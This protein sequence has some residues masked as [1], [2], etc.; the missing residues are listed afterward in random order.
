MILVDDS[1]HAARSSRQGDG[2]RAVE[3][4]AE[5][6]KLLDE[7]SSYCRD[8]GIAESTFGRL[9]I[10]DGKLMSR[11]RTGGRV[12]EE[13]GARVRAF[14]QTSR[15]PLRRRAA[16]SATAVNGARA[17]RPHHLSPELENTFRFF[18][19]RQKY[20]MFVTTSSEKWVVADRAAAE[21]ENIHP[22]PPAVR[23]FDAGVGEGSVLTRF[24]RA[25][26][27][28][29]PTAPF[30]IVGKE[31]SPEDVR[32]TLEKMPDR[33]FEHPATVLVMTNMHYAEAPWLKPRTV[34]AATSMVWHELAL[35]GSTGH[36]FERQISDLAPFLAEHWRA[37][38]GPTGSPVYEKPAVL[39]IYRKDY[40]LL[41]DSVLP[42]RGAVKADFDFV[43]ASQPYRAR[44]SVEFKAQKVIAPLARALGPGGRLLGIHSCGDGPG[45]EI[46]RR[47]WPDD[48]PF[49]TDRHQLL[50]AV[51]T[52]LGADARN[53]N[54]LAASDARA[55][56][57]YD[58]HTL[59]HEISGHIN[60]ST[61]LAA[62]NAATYVAQIEDD[63]LSS[64]ISHDAYLE[65][66]KDVLLKYGGLWFWD[67][68]YVI[69]R[70]QGLD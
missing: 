47:I 56:F 9:A 19:N 32:L 48:N 65:A 53:L 57:R 60:T 15:A 55:L 36:D 39:V 34:E 26:H 18:D 49:T 11:L 6:A 38:I 67:E 12:T 27:Q 7:I 37:R 24:M 62:W 64:V 68:T 50:R 22:R 1:N 21:L 35:T 61:L 4:L 20:L 40:R 33:F 2:T 10:N 46:I 54:F 58:M 52:E 43:L 13:T 44:A 16:H 30:Y 69:S 41:L 23:L 28:R 31:I 14:M 63:R 8:N 66:T 70:R 51:K 29:F 3:I 59:P 25:M 42:E 45:L 5:T 17:L